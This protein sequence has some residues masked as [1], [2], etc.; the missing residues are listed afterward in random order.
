MGSEPG[1]GMPDVW[2]VYLAVDDAAKTLEAA[3]AHGGQ[4]VVPAMAVGDLGT[5]AMIADN[6]GAAIGL[7]QPGQ[8][9][10]F[11]LLA[12]PA[13]PGWFEL[14]TRDYPATVSF[15]RDVFGWETQV[16]GDTPEFR[17]TLLV[18]GDEQLAGIMDAS[19]FLAAGKPARWSVYFGAA[20]TDATLAMVTQLGGRWSARPRTPRT[21]AW[22]KQPTRPG[23][24][25]SWS[26]RTRRCPPS[27][28]SGEA[29]PGTGSRPGWCRPAGTVPCAGRRRCQRGRAACPVLASTRWTRADS[30]RGL[31]GLPMYSST[32]RP[33]P[34]STSGSLARSVSMTT[35]MSLVCGSS[36]A[37]G[38][39][40]TR[41][42]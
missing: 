15:Y 4:V 12:E 33:R 25:S 31:N 23:A 24:G 26:G 30:S 40:R 32:P 14:F 17:Y 34:L 9:K 42:T 21:A 28:A 13:A 10:G 8:H 39:P 5:M 22:P 41:R 3:A 35:G 7:W 11:G 18:R 37:P 20:D 38:R 27:R 29:A 6:A 2:S 16:A 1:S 19:G 36:G